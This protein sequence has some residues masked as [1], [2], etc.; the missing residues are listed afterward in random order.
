MTYTQTQVEAAAKAGHEAYEAKAH[1]MGHVSGSPVPWEDVPEPY[2]SC[3]LA[4]IAAALAA[5]DAMQ[6]RP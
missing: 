6:D 2:R 4:S 5:A 3:T 1:E